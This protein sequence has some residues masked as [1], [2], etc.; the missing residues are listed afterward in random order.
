MKTITYKTERVTDVAVRGSLTASF[1]S[2]LLKCFKVI[3]VKVFL[4]L[5]LELAVKY[6]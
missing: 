1:A 5:L 4:A 6:V 2:G 3:T